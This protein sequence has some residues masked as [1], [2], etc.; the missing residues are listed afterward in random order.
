VQAI[1]DKLY[2][3]DYSIYY[4]NDRTKYA[5]KTERSERL[6]GAFVLM[7]DDQER[8]AF[9]ECLVAW[10]ARDAEWEGAASAMSDAFKLREMMTPN[11]LLNA[12]KWIEATPGT[13]PEQAIAKGHIA[14]LSNLMSREAI[15]LGYDKIRGRLSN[16]L[17]Q[18]AKE[19]NADRFLRLVRQLQT[20]FG[21]DVVGEDLAAWVAEAF[22]LRGKIAHGPLLRQSEQEYEL[23]AKAVHAAECFAYLML[24]SDLPMGEAGRKRVAHALMVEYYRAGIKG[25]SPSEF[26]K[27]KSK[28]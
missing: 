26:K 8:D 19:Q 15:K 6:H 23:F 25:T 22:T 16:S 3:V 21:A 7:H 5:E 10:F 2:P 4:Y 9:V 24:I 1:K 13:K 12:T 20:R 14:A 27:A 18:I 17:G 11:R 28:A